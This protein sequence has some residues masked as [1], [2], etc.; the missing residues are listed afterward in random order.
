MNR[1]LAFTGAA[2]L[3]VAGFAAVAGAAPGSAERGPGSGPGFARGER[4][5]RMALARCARLKERL[6]GIDRGF[7][8]EQIRDIA[9]GRLAARD[10]TNLKVG[11]VTE[12]DG[13][14][15]LEIVTKDGALVE[16]REVSL[17][18]GLD[19]KAGANCEEN[20]ARRA[21]ARR[22]ADRGGDRGPPG[23]AGFGRGGGLGDL[24]GGGGRNRDLD[25]SADDVKKLAE[26]AL[27]LQ[28][29]D[30]LKVGK[31]TEKDADTF[32]V[33]IV[34]RDNSLVVT[35]EVNKHSGRWSRS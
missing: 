7:T 14:V 9:Q 1:K 12:T 8:A 27:V 22:D 30:R 17:K 26:A 29:N 5:E 24:P 31:V 6:A 32:A 2:A 34:T 11:K 4:L 35:R 28:G 25:L 19:P 15:S 16:T 13:V 10:L 3:I 21:D 18:T 23:R 33:D 20:A